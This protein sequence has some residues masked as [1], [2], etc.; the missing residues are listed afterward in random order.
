MTNKTLPPFPPGCEDSD[1]DRPFFPD[2][3]VHLST[4]HDGNIGAVMDTVRRALARADRDGVPDPDAV[5][6]WLWKRI[7]AS[8]SP[9]EALQWVMRTV[10]VT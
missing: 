7:F 6:N 4:G 1:P 10:H 5:A 3:T 9:D 8:E 2:V